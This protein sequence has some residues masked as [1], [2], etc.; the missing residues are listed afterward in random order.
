MP[1][2]RAPPQPLD[3]DVDE[4]LWVREEAVWRCAEV[5]RSGRVCG[6]VLASLQGLKDHVLRRHYG[7]PIPTAPRN[8]W[9]Y[10][11]PEPNYYRLPLFNVRKIRQMGMMSD[12][13][14]V[15]PSDANVRPGWNTK[16]SRV[17]KS[18]LIS[19]LGCVGARRAY[20]NRLRP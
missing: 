6:K 7:R 12:S 16:S 20:R 14:D 11:L 15:N 13:P 1:K 3:E 2:K 8:V 5:S 9:F 19:D 18:R 4:Q 17:T 10:Y